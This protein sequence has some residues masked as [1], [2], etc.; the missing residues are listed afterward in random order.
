MSI[1]ASQVA[2]AVKNQLPMQKT[3]EMWAQSPGQ[4]EGT[5]LENTLQCS[6]LES[7]M[8]RG[9]WLTTVH[10]ATKGWT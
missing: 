3:E 6:Y 10:R 4:E 8:D 5:Y 2:L 9:A 1:R 7:P